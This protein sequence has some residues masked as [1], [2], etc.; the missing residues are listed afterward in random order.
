MEEKLECEQ[1]LII[2]NEKNQVRGPTIFI[3]CIDND[4]L[5]KVMRWSVD[6]S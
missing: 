2:S 3:D 4:I 1:K 5:L 6:L